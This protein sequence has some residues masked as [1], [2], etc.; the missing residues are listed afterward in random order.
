[1]KASFSR[2]INFDRDG[3]AVKAYACDNEKG[4]IFQLP[5]AEDFEDVEN[6]IASIKADY[7]LKTED[8]T[9]WIEVG[10]VERP[11]VENQ[12][13]LFQNLTNEGVD[14]AGVKIQ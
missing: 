3:R 2:F 14:S 12:A 6:T 4:Y 7:K 9:F 1:M 8:L 5:I 13:K 11:E 10:G